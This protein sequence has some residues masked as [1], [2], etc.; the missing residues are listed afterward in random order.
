MENKKYILTIVIVLLLVA[1]ASWITN[2]KEVII[3]RI[4]Y[5]RDFDEIYSSGELR[6]IVEDNKMSYY[7]VQCDKM[8]MCDSLEGLQVKMVE[9]FG[10]KHGLNITFIEERDLS[11]A[12]QML[13]NNNV[14]L[15]AWHIPIYD[16]MKEHI[17]YTIPVFTSRQKLIQRK[18]SSD[19]KDT[20]IFITNQLDLA[21]KIVY[22]VPGSIF[23]QRLEHLQQEI[24]DTIYLREIPGSNDDLL[25]RLVSDTIIDYSV[26]DEFVAR[27]LQKDY[28]TVDM[29]TAVSFTQNYSW[30]VSPKST[31]LLDSLNVWLAEYLESKEYNKIYRKYTGVK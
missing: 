9:E 1:I 5:H 12:R 2:N 14:D 22:I 6:V 28:P 24:G 8:V 23:K 4:P 11:K 17:S 7:T 3:Q 19:K 29:T 27:V 31:D 21:E 25:F 13:L 16:D 30:G 20:T 15:L 26:C 10:K 18:R